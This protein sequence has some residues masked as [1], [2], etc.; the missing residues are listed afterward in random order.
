[1][2]SYLVVRGTN[3]RIEAKERKERKGKAVSECDMRQMSADGTASTLEAIMFNWNNISGMEEEMGGLAVGNGER[4]VE[5]GPFPRSCSREAWWKSL[6]KEKRGRCQQKCGSAIYWLTVH[7]KNS[8][9]FAHCMR[10][11]DT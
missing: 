1:M 5:E 3:R 10:S 11:V 4:A 2:E 7:E 6:Q 9:R 8:E